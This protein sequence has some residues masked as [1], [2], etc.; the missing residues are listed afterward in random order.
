LISNL[1]RIFSCQ[2]SQKDYVSSVNRDEFESFWDRLNEL[3]M[4]KEVE[5]SSLVNCSRCCSFII[6]SWSFLRFRFNHSFAWSISSKQVFHI[7]SLSILSNNSQASTSRSR[8]VRRLFRS[9]RKTSECYEHVWINQS[10]DLTLI[11]L[12]KASHDAMFSLNL[13][14]LYWILRVILSTSSRCSALSS[15]TSFIIL[16]DKHVWHITSHLYQV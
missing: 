3:N 10:S 13:A 9:S 5:V 11:N 4:M 7:C 15:F 6:W 1:S 14:H 8:W 2:L 12:I 16:L